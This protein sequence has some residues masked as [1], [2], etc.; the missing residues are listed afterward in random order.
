[1]LR[2]CD[3]LQA[4]DKRVPVRVACW[5]NLL[6]IFFLLPLWAPGLL[7]Q[8]NQDISGKVP[9]HAV[10]RDS[11]RIKRP[12]LSMDGYFSGL[13]SALFESLSSPFIMEQLLH[14]RL[15]LDLPFSDQV[16]L[17]AG[18]RNRLFTGDMVRA[19]HDY[20]VLTA[21][22]PGWMDLSWNLLEEHSF[23][24]NT[25]FDRLSLDITAGK[26]EIRIGRQRIN[27]GQTLVWNPNDIFNAYSFFDVDYPEKPGSDAVRVQYYPSFSSVMELAVS[28]NRAG[29]VTAAGLWRFNRKGYDVQ[30]LGGYAGSR[31]VVA[32]TGWSGNIGTISFRGE[33]TLF[34]PVKKG[35]PEKTMLLATTGFEKTMKGNSLAIVQLMYCTNPPDL[36]EF[37][38][39]YTTTLSAR[40]LAFSE[41]TAF[42]QYTWAATPLLNMT[43]AAMWFPDLKGIFTGP[44]LDFSMAENVD[45]SLLWQHFSGDFGSGAT[46]INLAFLR[47]SYSF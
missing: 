39:L 33:A 20:A 23:F 7:A 41:F 28:L 29:E 9:E 32:G 12:V 24:L 27:W 35:V 22:D 3:Q 26:T 45:L 16:R 4:G 40:N 21:R 14:N 5:R 1:M 42:G 18:I 2:T 36:E 19:E 8:G 10:P 13:N 44:S 37:A 30:L 6:I 31:D 15:N 25:A 38:S 43:L 47:F 17:T 34:A 11:T 46:H